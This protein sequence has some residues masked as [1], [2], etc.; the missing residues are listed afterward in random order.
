MTCGN[1]PDII[2]ALL[3]KGSIPYGQYTVGNI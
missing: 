1:Y 3:I 2:L